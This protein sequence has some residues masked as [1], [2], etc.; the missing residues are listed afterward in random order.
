MINNLNKANFW[1]ALMIKYPT[2]VKNFC[3][4]IDQ[5]KKDVNWDEVFNANRPIAKWDGKE[6]Y[7]SD[8]STVA[9]KFHDIPL[10]MQYGILLKY[11]GDIGKDTLSL[12]VNAITLER[13]MNQFEGLF[14]IIENNISKDEADYK[15]AITIQKVVVEKELYQ[16][17]TN[18]PSVVP[19]SINFDGVPIGTATVELDHENKCYVADLRISDLKAYDRLRTDKEHAIVFPAVGVRLRDGD[20]TEE[21]VVKRCELYEVSICGQVNADP[22]IPPIDFTKRAL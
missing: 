6:G 3:D 4:W 19:L 16:T 13:A 21:G 10:E 9:P 18:V 1:D 11:A 14:M 8:K 5:Y 15:K 7:M 20:Q 17:I 12:Q 2:A 22:T